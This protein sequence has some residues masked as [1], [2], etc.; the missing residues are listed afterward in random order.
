[1]LW[2]RCVLHVL[3]LGGF[4]AALPPRLGIVGQ[5]RAWLLPRVL[6]VSLTAVS[7]AGLLGW[8]ALFLGSSL[9]WCRQVPHVLWLRNGLPGGADVPGS[10][11]NLPFRAWG[12][13]VVSE[14]AIMRWITSLVAQPSR[15][16]R[17]RPRPTP[18]S[19][20]FLLLFLDHFKSLY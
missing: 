15:N 2:P 10:L 14:A 17:T 6:A 4:S 13:A 7:V 3:P 12:R 5:R 8:K 1:M 11:Q 18:S 16:F 20:L 19:A 9:T